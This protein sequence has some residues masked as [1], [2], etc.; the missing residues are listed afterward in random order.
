MATRPK[1]FISYS[2]EDKEWLERLLVHLK[3]LERGGTIDL[4]DDT[5]IKTGDR[6]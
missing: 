1:I 6:W 4:W 5:R 2:H 3:P